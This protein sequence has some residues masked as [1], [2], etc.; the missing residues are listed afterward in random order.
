MLPA[1]AGRQ[2]ATS[3]CTLLRASKRGLRPLPGTP[4]KQRP[5]T[6]THCNCLAAARTGT[7]LSAAALGHQNHTRPSK[8]IHIH[9]HSR[10]FRPQI[11]PRCHP[12]PDTAPGTPPSSSS[13]RPVFF[14]LLGFQIRHFDTAFQDPSPTVSACQRPTVL[15]IGSRS[16]P[17]VHQA[18]RQVHDNVR[19]L[20]RSLRCRGAPCAVTLSRPASP[21]R[22]HPRPAQPLLHEFA[23]PR[24]AGSGLPSCRTQ[25][26]SRSWLGFV[27]R[28]G[29]RSSRAVSPLLALMAKIRAPSR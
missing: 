21:P 25:I 16:G 26:A 19:S 20:A 28:I 14:P 5:P 12:T 10:R 22:A 15:S 7:R 6:T 17:A 27:R 9:I 18:P 4:M 24:S 13:S 1:A 3:G 29:S 23:L 2:T 11:R 8:T